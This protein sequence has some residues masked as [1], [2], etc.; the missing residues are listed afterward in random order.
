MKGLCIGNQLYGAEFGLFGSVNGR[1]DCECLLLRLA[2]KIPASEVIAHI[3]KYRLNE[4]DCVFVRS[5]AKQYHATHVGFR[6]SHSLG[7]IPSGCRMLNFNTLSASSY[8]VIKCKSHNFF[9]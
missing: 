4:K 3:E 1:N 7:Y 6:T 5:K 8:L 9:H 2:A